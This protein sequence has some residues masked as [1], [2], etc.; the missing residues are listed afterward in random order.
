[1]YSLLQFPP[2]DLILSM[3]LLNSTEFSW[4]YPRA[5]VI[6]CVR[7]NGKKGTLDRLLSN[8]SISKFVKNTTTM[9]GKRA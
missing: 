1:M 4:I 2:V 9:S 7:R 8:T 5:I 3:I 6:V